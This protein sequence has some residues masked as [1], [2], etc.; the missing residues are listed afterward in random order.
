MD[1]AQ[2]IWISGGFIA[3]GIALL[4]IVLGAASRSRAR[5]ADRAAA[6]LRELMARADTLAND[7]DK[8]VEARIAQ[9]ERALAAAG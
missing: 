3:A 8:R 1:Q 5:Q 9:L 6:N 2:L 7:V 4:L